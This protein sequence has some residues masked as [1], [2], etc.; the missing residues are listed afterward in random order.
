MQNK[1]GAFLRI[2]RAIIFDQK[3]ATADI[4]ILPVQ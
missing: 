2:T 1:R 4:A 3:I